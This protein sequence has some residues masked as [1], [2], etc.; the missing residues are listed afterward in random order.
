MSAYCSTIEHRANA[1]RSEQFL[2]GVANHRWP[3]LSFSTPVSNPS[4][5][6]CAWPAH[7]TNRR[8]LVMRVVCR[9]V[10]SLFSDCGQR[11]RGGSVVALSTTGSIGQPAPVSWR[12]HLYS[13]SQR[14]A[15]HRNLCLS[16]S[17][18]SMSY[19]VHQLHVGE[20]IDV[21]GRR[22]LPKYH[23]I[24]VHNPEEAVITF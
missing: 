1:T 18:S 17:Q 2:P 20:G 6:A 10:R 21:G 11:G 22:P 16:R 23:H 5:P 14:W 3:P 24:G 7:G 13:I 9:R 19:A 15:A 12:S 4:Q 8:L